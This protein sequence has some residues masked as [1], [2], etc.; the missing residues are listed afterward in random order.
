MF[1]GKT[2][3]LQP[4]DTFGYKATAEVTLLQAQ[5]YLE[6]GGQGG[7]HAWYR[8]D[9]GNPIPPPSATDI[10][11]YT[12]IFRSNTQTP[13]ALTAL[14]SNA[15]KG[16]IREAV[17]AH[18]Q[19]L[20][21]PPSSDLKIVIPKLKKEHTNPYFDVWAWSN[22]NL[23]WGGPVAG[24]GKVHISHALLPVLYHH[25]GC[26]V[27]SYEALCIIQQVSKGRPIIDLGSGNGYWT[28]MLRKFDESPKKKMT[29]VPVDSGLSEWRTMWIG[30]TVGADGV[31]YLQQNNGGQSDV[32]LL[33]YPQVG[34]DFTGK[35]LRAYSMFNLPSPSPSTFFLETSLTLQS[36]RATPSSAQAH[37]TQTASPPLQKKPLPTGWRKRCHSLKRRVRSLCPASP[38][39]TRLCTYSKRRP[40]HKP[41]SSR[42]SL[43]LSPPVLY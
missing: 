8:D 3:G 14:K 7:L 21:L 19:S 35:I 29:V 26:V 24:T 32:L 25:F 34:D 40:S 39:R 15:K 31:K 5:T 27:P 10:A 36:Q 13:K 22:Q 2:F 6:Y 17:A 33:V 12:D 9:E 42:T 23:E 43:S 41:P 37:K 30:D 16:T 4:S 20:Y 38:Q 11:A 18:L 1:I 28:F